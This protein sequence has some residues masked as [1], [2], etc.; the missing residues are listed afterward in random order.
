MPLLD[1]PIAVWGA[2]CLIIC[3]LGTVIAISPLFGQRGTPPSIKV[4][5]TLALSLIFLPMATTNLPAVPAGLL[6]FL[7]LV[8]REVLIGAVI[9]LAV[10]L[11][12]VSLQAAG[13]IVGVQ[14][15]FQLG[16]TINPM[17]GDQ[18][19]LIDELYALLATMV[20]FG[21][22]GHHLVLVAVQRSYDLLPMGVLD[23]ARVLPD[24]ALLLAWGGELFVLATRIAMPVAAALLL[25]DV[26]LALVA[27]SLPQLNVFVLGAPAKVAIG[28]VMLTATVPVTVL[29]M[30]QTIRGIAAVTARLLGGG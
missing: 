10:L 13:Q 30:T 29:V 16:A 17:L 15:G 26:A 8:A 11:M 20:F 14:I 28:L 1:Q 7:V 24:V 27:R 9:G 12:F 3:R 22:D 6:P 2:F 23:G 5:V 18:M 21:I 4:A 25:A 19:G